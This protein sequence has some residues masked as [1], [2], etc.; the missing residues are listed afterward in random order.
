MNK[1]LDPLYF[2]ASIG[3]CFT[4]FGEKA[5]FRI[6]Y[7][8]SLGS[9]VEDMPV[10][11]IPRSYINSLLKPILSRL[12]K[13]KLTQEYYR[14]L[15]PGLFIGISTTEQKCIERGINIKEFILMAQK[16]DKIISHS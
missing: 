16:T 7:K 6:E 2:I 14:T 1:L 12:L 5:D 4:P 10:D 13:K 3:P 9:A 15:G 11:L 8:D